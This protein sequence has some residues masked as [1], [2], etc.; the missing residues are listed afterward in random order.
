MKLL[1]P[2]TDVSRPIT[3]RVK[4]AL[5]SVL[6]KYDLPNGK[7]VADLF[8]GV[9]SLGLEALSRGADFVCFVEQDSKIAAVLEKNIEKAGFINQ[10]QV[11]RADAFKMGVWHGQHGVFSRAGSPCYYDLIFVDPPYASMQTAYFNL[12]AIKYRWNC[13]SK[14]RRANRTIESIWLIRDNRAAPVG[15]DGSNDIAK[16]GVSHKGTKTQRNEKS[17]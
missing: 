12:R 15:D 11:I 10:S 13:R 9:G 4:E 8:C 2:K 6:C 7:V 14:N 3:D 1:S 16:A 17:N 5:F